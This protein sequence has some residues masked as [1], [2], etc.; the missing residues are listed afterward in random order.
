MERRRRERDFDHVLRVRAGRALY[1]VQA[2]VIGPKRGPGA[3]EAAGVVDRQ[4]RLEL[5]RPGEDVGLIDPVFDDPPELGVAR[6]IAPGVHHTGKSKSETPPCPPAYEAETPSRTGAGDMRLAAWAP[7]VGGR[8]R[9][10]V[11]PFPSSLNSS[12]SEPPCR[13]ASSRL[14]KRPSPVPGCGPRPGS[15]IRK[16]RSK[17]LSCLSRAMPMPRSSMIRAGPPSLP[18]VS[19]PHG[20]PRRE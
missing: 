16:K 10:K 1:L 18:P 5:A 9:T 2:E 8:R 19:R 3:V 11:L 6:A 7:L 14:M 20:G 4:V 15:S 17:I 13:S 12:L